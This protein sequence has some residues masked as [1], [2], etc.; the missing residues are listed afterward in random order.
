MYSNQYSRSSGYGPPPP[1]AHSNQLQMDDTAITALLQNKSMAELQQI[2]ENEGKLDDI[3]QDLQQVKNINTERE[4]SLASNKSIADYNLSLQPRFE[5]LKR[6]VATEYEQLN[7]LKT[8]LATDIAKLDQHSSQQSLDTLLA[9]LQTEAAKA[10]EQTED[11]ASEFCSKEID[12]NDFLQKYI[13]SRKEAHTK[14]IKSEKM[15]EIIRNPSSSVHINYSSS[16]STSIT[17]YSSS[18]QSAPYPSNNAMP[19][20]RMPYGGMGY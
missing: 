2:L 11:L 3:I 8:E 10:E 6:E 18:S 9:V 15:G 14:R 17:S 5:Q 20:P 7:T 13:P 4:T 19:V 12:V 1:A 16:V